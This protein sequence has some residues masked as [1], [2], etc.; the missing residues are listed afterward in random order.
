[1]QDV[2]D[3]QTW[4]P[5]SASTAGH[6]LWPVTSLASGDGGLP[7]PRAA[8][9]LMG[10]SGCFAQT[11]TQWGSE[12]A[13]G[14]SSGVGE[15]SSAGLDLQQGQEDK[16]PP[17]PGSAGGSA[18]QLSLC[19]C[20]ERTACGDRRTRVMPFRS[21]RGSGC[22]ILNTGHLVTKEPG[23]HCG[24]LI[25]DISF[26]CILKFYLKG[27]PS[28]NAVVYQANPSPAA[29]SHRWLMSW[30]LHFW[31]APC[32]GPGKA[33]DDGPRPWVLVPMWETWRIPPLHTGPAVATVAMWGINQLM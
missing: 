1:M 21:G 5:G 30:H 19:P 14:G 9:R 28:A 26:K 22:L 13:G 33:V 7:P 27:S 31:S 16:P 20:H 8:L 2:G 10:A 29:L 15:G 17:G 25:F 23:L 12:L 11:C 18:G 3:K 4:S 32:R 6:L 24:F